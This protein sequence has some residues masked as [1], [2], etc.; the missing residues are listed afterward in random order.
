MIRDL[1]ARFFGPR[2]DFGSWS[3]KPCWRRGRFLSLMPS[4]IL[5]RHLLWCQKHVQEGSTEEQRS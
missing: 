3:A 1:L 2:C 5:K 4:L